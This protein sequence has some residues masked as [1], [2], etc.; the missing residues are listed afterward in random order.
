MLDS[1]LDHYNKKI[2]IGSIKT[3]KEHTYPIDNKKSI[4]KIYIFYSFWEIVCV[5]IQCYKIE[6][7]FLDT[8][9][10]YNNTS[11]KKEMSILKKIKKN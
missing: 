4:I 9:I 2:K 3:K 5:Y 6:Y 7:I 1:F 11:Q 8:Y 10:V